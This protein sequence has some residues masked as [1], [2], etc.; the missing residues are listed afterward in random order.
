MAPA[1]IRSFNRAA[2][3]A[4][5]AGPLPHA[6]PIKHVRDRQGPLAHPAA[7]PP[8]QA[9]KL[10]RPRFAAETV[11]QLLVPNPK[12]VRHPSSRPYLGIVGR[13]IILLAASSAQEF[14]VA[15]RRRPAWPQ[16]LRERVS[17]PRLL[18]TS[19]CSPSTVVGQQDFRPKTPYRPWRLPSIPRCR[20]G[21]PT[22]GSKG[23]GVIVSDWTAI[24]SRHTRRLR[25]Q[26]G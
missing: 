3:S 15:C 10:C 22:S 2:D 8:R 11:D 20:S 23:A 18:L 25:R 6:H 13:R 26:C 5:P 24:G 9:S 12:A 14:P 17:A 21:R 7:L 1:T 4:P 19:L 16:Q